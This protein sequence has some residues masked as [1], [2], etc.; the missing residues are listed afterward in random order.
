[1]SGPDFLETLQQKVILFDGGM[2]SMLIAAGLSSGETPEAWVLNRPEEIAS[3][4]RAYLQAGADVLTTATFGA[5][6]LKLASSPEGRSLDVMAV[7]E[8]AVEIARKAMEDEGDSARFLAGDIGPSGQFFPPL[9]ALRPSDARASFR[10][11][12]KALRNAGVDLF[13]IETMYDLREALDAL[14]AVRELSDLPVLVCLTFDQKPRGFFTIMGD[15]PGTAVDALLQEGA[16]GLGANCT[17]GSRTMIELAGTFRPLTATPLLFQPNAGQPVMEGE[18]PRYRQQAPEFA[19]DMMA[20]L[21]AGAN[22][23]GGCCG[24]TPDFIRET[25]KLLQAN[26]QEGTG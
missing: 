9:G 10:Q 11:Q 8:G 12:A 15:T 6:C 5:S 22:A 4:H 20:I 16:S 21:Q 14:R 24:T 18:I 26:A 19:Q 1:M 2:G 7:N 23:I 3:V 13:L 25:R 17:L